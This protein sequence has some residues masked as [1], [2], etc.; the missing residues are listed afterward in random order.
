[1]KTEG[2]K[3]K[4]N[5]KDG[6]QKVLWWVGRRGREEQREELVKN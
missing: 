1:M 3:K 4:G 5:T 2:R 6:S